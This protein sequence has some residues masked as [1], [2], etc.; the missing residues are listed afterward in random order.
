MEKYQEDATN[1]DVYNTMLIGCQLW[2]EH[3]DQ[4]YG[5]CIL[6]HF[7]DIKS[8]SGASYVMTACDMLS[9]KKFA[10]YHEEAKCMLRYVDKVYDDDS[11]LFLANM[12][13]DFPMVI[14]T[15]TTYGDGSEKTTTRSYTK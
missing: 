10:E 1:Y 7:E 5:K 9:H 2:F 13:C 15:R 14:R 8:D 11:S 4:E 3:N 6:N 12:K